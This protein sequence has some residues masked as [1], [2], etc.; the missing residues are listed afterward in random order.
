VRSVSSVLVVE[1]STGVRSNAGVGCA[2]TELLPG[3]RKTGKLLGS[4]FDTRKIIAAAPTIKAQE[5]QT[6]MATIPP[7]T[8]D[9]FLS[10]DLSLQKLFLLHG[11]AKRMI[12]ITFL[13]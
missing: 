3:G 10:I 12:R 4:P 9:R 7:T 5:Q 1:E 11:V 13:T 2:V 6:K 8:F